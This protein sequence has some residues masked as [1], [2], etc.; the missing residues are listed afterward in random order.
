[1]REILNEGG[2]AGGTGDGS[3]RGWYTGSRASD[4]GTLVDDLSPEAQQTRRVLTDTT[5]KKE[6]GFVSNA[7][8]RVALLLDPWYKKCD[9]E[10][11]TN[12]G[13][14]FKI[15]CMSEVNTCVAESF[16]DP[17]IKSPDE[18][19]CS[20]GAGRAGV[21]PMSPAAK[22]TNLGLLYQRRPA[23][24][25][26]TACSEEPFE[27]NKRGAAGVQHRDLLREE[28]QCTWRKT[29]TR[30]TRTSAFFNF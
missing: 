17:T 28:L 29:F 5:S 3:F 19:S 10:A 18:L 27:Q 25:K 22:K 7:E 21:T 12:G 14:V 26:A 4:G 15:E 30:R 9:E 6:L 1:M 16:S 8:E 23:R 13:P 2:H 20:Q 11:C 24:L